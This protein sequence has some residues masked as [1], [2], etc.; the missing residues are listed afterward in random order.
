[1][2]EQSTDGTEH[3][4]TITRV[5]K[6]RGAVSD[7]DRLLGDKKHVNLHGEE[8]RVGA[9]LDVEDELRCSYEC[10]CGERFLKEQ[11]AADH[12]RENRSV[13]KATEQEG[14]DD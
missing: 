11:T 6:H 9:P 5:L 7:P 14:I 8:R 2:S 4:I 1:M 12:L 10:S 13:D 3:I